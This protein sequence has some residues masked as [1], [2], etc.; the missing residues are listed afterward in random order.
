MKFQKLMIFTAPDECHIS[1]LVLSHNKLVSL[2]HDGI[3]QGIK[4]LNNASFLDST[5]KMQ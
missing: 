3:I 4:E 2:V 1:K 5:Q